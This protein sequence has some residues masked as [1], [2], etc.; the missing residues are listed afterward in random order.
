MSSAQSLPRPRTRQ[1]VVS[2]LALVLGAGALPAQGSPADSVRPLINQADDPALRGFRWRVIGP[3]GQGGRVDD[4]A[5]VERDPQTYYIGFA[6]GGIW[7]TSNNGVTFTPVFDTYSTHSIGDIAVAPSNPEIVYA[8]TGEA[9]NRQSSSFG[10]GVYKT[11]DGGKTWTSMGL[12]ET[13]SI[14]RVVVHPTNP[15]VVWVAANGR[16]FG[17]NAERGIYKSSDGGR[18]WRKTLFVDDN[19][20]ATDI[21]VHPRNPNVLFAATYTRRRT[22]WGFASGGPGSGIWKSTNGGES[23]SRVRGGGLP[24]GTMGRIGLDFAR[25]NPNV[26]YAQIEVAP[27]KEAIATAAA[28]PAAAGGGGGGGGGQQALP[29][30]DKVSGIWRSSDGGNSWEFRSNQNNRPMYYSQVRVDPNDP[31]TV[32]VGGGSASKSIDGARTFT[33]LTG[34]GHGDHHAIWIDPNNSRHVMYGNDGS[35]DVSWDAG[36]TWE[37]LRTWA[38]GQPYHASVDMRRPYYVCTG[39]QDNGSW[40]GPS[41]VRSGPILA[42]DWYRVGGG[43]GFYSAV[44]PTDHMIVY[45]ESQDGN[46]SRLDLREAT[47]VVIRPRPG[48][49]A[50]DAPPQANVPAAFRPNVVPEAETPTI[51]RFNWNTPLILSP[52]DA[53]TVFVAGNRLFISK[54]RGTTWRMTGDLTKQ[55]NRDEREILGLRGSLPGCGRARIGAC[56]L[57][58]HDGTQ[59]FGNAISFAESSIMPGVYWYGSDDGSIQVSRDAGD[60]W[61]EVGKNIP[62]G[63][64]EYY[65]SR[66]EPSHFDVATAYVSIDGHKSDDLKP[67]VYVTRDFG[68]TWTSI[69]SD[70]P[71]VGNVNTVRQDLK[72]PNLLYAGTEFGFFVS[73]DEGKSWKKFMTNLPVVRIDDVTIHPRDNDLVLSTHGRSVWIM[74]DVS[75]LQQLTPETLTRD[76]TLFEVRNAVAWKPDIRLRRSVTGAKNF[77]GENAPAG[78]KISYWLANAPSGDVKITITDVATGQVFRTIDG[79]KQQGM[80]RVQWNLCSDPRPAQPAQGGGFGA[81]GPCAGVGGGGGGEGAPAQGPPR[82]GRLA[83]PGAYAVTLTVGGKTYSRPVSV[84]EDVWMHER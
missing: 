25:S 79:T 49:R 17:P 23:W 81:G 36:Q 59:S 6:T 33:Q 45:S 68:R 61:T 82:V 37:A 57:S 58:K 11:T 48:G 46:M 4:I 13:Q 54:D 70:L 47:T 56:I 35:V 66:V 12:R 63:T 28:Q 21:V 71:A 39:L 84:L 64:K 14:A 76:A 3:I 22:V 78:T 38:V 43:D 44:D 16:L 41:S 32:Y 67:Y 7:K 51:P 65:I 2:L 52:H 83:S 55:I 75:A 29:P 30:D 9:N 19:T 74:D 31:N 1:A 27:D 26:L 53:S 8:G 40:C 15:N 69:S 5:V 80:N 42:Q 20:G 60:T 62:G 50:V 10:D 72:N 77:Q 18:T 73:L 34:F 24:N